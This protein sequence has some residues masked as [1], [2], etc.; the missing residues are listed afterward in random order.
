[1]GPGLGAVYMHRMVSRRGRLLAAGGR[2]PLA[3]RLPAACS[4]LRTPFQ[5]CV[6][7]SG[8]INRHI[9]RAEVA[10]RQWRVLAAPS[11]GGDAAAW[12]TAGLALSESPGS[13]RRPPSFSHPMPNQRSPTLLLCA[14]AF[15]AIC[16]HAS[17]K[18][19]ELSIDSETRSRRSN[20]HR[21]RP[22]PRTDCRVAAPPLCAGRGALPLG[23]HATRRQ[24]P[25]L[26]RRLIINGENVAGPAFGFMVRLH[27]PAQRQDT[28]TAFCG[29]ALL[30]ERTVL[31]GEHG[32]RAQCL[33]RRLILS[34]RG[35]GR[36]CSWQVCMPPPSPGVHS[37]DGAAAAQ[38]TPAAAHCFAMRTPRAALEP[39]RSGGRGGWRRAVQRDQHLCAPRYHT[40][41]P[42]ARPGAAAG[43][44]A[45]GGASGGASRG[46]CMFM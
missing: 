10:A 34:R 20:L 9:S 15:Q 41:Q 3:C 39:Q 23:S 21:R 24:L 35:G 7:D 14:L 25:E 33:P 40:L 5:M 43:K 27:V 11:K 45:S 44:G 36:R 26:S 30:D 46:A 29:G 31:T 37:A 17:G 2:A 32:T 22:T 1:M 6:V 12:P 19:P 13:A 38:P 42:L 28:S 4:S 18:S 8:Q 16:V